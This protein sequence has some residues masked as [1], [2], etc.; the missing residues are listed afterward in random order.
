MEAASAGAQMDA[1][2]LAAELKSWMQ[3]QHLCCCCLG[4]L[5]PPKFPKR[6]R[7]LHVEVMLWAGLA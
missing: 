6:R 5:Q 2:E 3:F 4:I 1:G 7:Q